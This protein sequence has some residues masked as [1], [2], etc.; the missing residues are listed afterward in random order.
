MKTRRMMG[1]VLLLLLSGC[2]M[3]LAVRGQDAPPLLLAGGAQRRVAVLS[4]AVPAELRV[5]GL[6]LAEVRGAWERVVYTSLAEAFD[7][8]R[9]VEG[10]QPGRYDLYVRPTVAVSEGREALVLRQR[11]EVFDGA[12][13]PLS[14]AET[15][16]PCAALSCTAAMMVAFADGAKVALPPALAALAEVRR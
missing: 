5:R 12:G 3:R 6:K 14:V 16:A 8:V 10:V 4:G 11:L 15:Q 1:G 9:F 7:V 2:G 13:R